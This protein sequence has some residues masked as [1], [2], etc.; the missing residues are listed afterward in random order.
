MEVLVNARKANNNK[1]IPLTVNVK[2]PLTEFYL[3]TFFMLD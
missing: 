1:I 2:I 3:F